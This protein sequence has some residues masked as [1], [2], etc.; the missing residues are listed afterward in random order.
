LQKHEIET[1]QA[2]PQYVENQVLLTTRNQGLA[3]IEKKADH[4]ETIILNFL[5][6]R[7]KTVEKRRIK[8]EEIGRIEAIFLQ[9]HIDNPE[10]FYR[11][12]QLK[13][14]NR[15]EQVKRV[16]RYGRECGNY[17][18]IS[19]NA[20][21]SDYIDGDFIRVIYN[22]ICH[23]EG[24]IPDLGVTEE[25]FREKILHSYKK[26]MGIKMLNGRRHFNDKYEYTPEK[27]KELLHLTDE[28]LSHL[29]NQA[30]EI[31]TEIYWEDLENNPLEKKMMVSSSD[32]HKRV[33]VPSGKV[34]GYMNP[35]GN[36]F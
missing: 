9:G 27:M 36:F 19:E 33:G 13:Q 5:E 35:R 23:G 3:N 28:D 4:R 25:E 32:S 20:E 12:E 26:R 16:Y 1:I 29:R 14:K 8:E 22:Y 15:T 31:L 11:F 2:I 10:L 7:E 18:E 17:K 6:K 21:V 34:F 30:K 24:S